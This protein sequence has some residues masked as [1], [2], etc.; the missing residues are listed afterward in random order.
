MTY[1]RSVLRLQLAAPALVGAILI[2]GGAAS[3]CVARTANLDCSHAPLTELLREHGQIVGD[4]EPWA[5]LTADTLIDSTSSTLW[6]GVL[7]EGPR[8]GAVIAIDCRGGGSLAYRTGYP[9]ELA[10]GPELPEV[11]STLI[12]KAVTREGT[13]YEQHKQFILG[14]RDGA[15]QVIWSGIIYER[16][17]AMLNKFGAESARAITVTGAGETLFV[18]GYSKTLV[19][20][21]N[22]VWALRD[23][24]SIASESFCFSRATRRYEQCGGRQ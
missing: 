18:S 21:G 4:G 22:D 12:V 10:R 24:S 15:I 6:L 20:E 7:W 19:H 11:G 1:R 16:D 13:G 14:K 3:A 9:L 8:D 23:S 5:G 17:Q 2:L